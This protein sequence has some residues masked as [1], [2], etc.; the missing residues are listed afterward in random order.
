M[1]SYPPEKWLG[2]GLKT[3]GLRAEFANKQPADNLR[4]KF[5]PV[6]SHGYLRFKAGVFRSLDMDYRDRI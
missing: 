3:V 5:K 2:S 6:F 4:K 1:D